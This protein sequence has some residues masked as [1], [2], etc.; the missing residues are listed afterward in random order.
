MTAAPLDDKTLAALVAGK[1]V[2]AVTDANGR[3]VGYFAPAGSRDE[4]ARP[5]SGAGAARQRREDGHDGAGEGVP[6]VSGA[7]GMRYTVVW[8]E[9]ALQQLAGIWVG[10]NDRARATR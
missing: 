2:V 9:T 10:A 8:R 1:R 3:V 6:P 4:M 7:E 5:G